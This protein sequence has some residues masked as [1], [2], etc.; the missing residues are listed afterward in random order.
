MKTGSI[1]KLGLL[2]ICAVVLLSVAAM[3]MGVNNAGER[4]VVQ[5]PNGTMFVKFE[6]GWYLSL[7]GK[8]NAYNDV[9]TFDFDKNVNSQD[10]TLDQQGIQ[11]RY[12]D[13]GTG[14]IFGIARFSLPNDEESMLKL[15]KQFRSYEGVAYKLIKPSTEESNNLT[16]ALMSSEEAYAEKRSTFTEWSKEQLVVGLYKTEI[17]QISEEDELSGKRVTKNVPTIRM[18]KDGLVE[19]YTSDLASYGV[20]VTGYQI[21]DWDFEEK[22]LEQ[23]AAKRMATMAIITAK[24]QAEEAKQEALTAEEKGKAA[25]MVAKY[26]KE[27]TKEQA[28]VEAT[29]A[30]EV[31]VI[32]AEQLV[33]VAEQALLEQTQKTL[34]ADQYKEEQILLG[35]GD[36]E[37]K[38]L[39]LEADGALEQKLAT[40][41]KVSQMFADA[42]S[43]Q[44]WVPDLQIGSSTSGGKSGNAAQ[45]LMDLFLI[46]SAKELQL[47]MTITPN[48][49]TPLTTTPNNR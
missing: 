11:V 14:T 12:Q 34:T 33:L 24:A 27:V 9:L 7:F 38:K 35:E 40:Y 16:A 6:P 44:K 19:H 45:N 15:H 32:E 22:T 41:E 46:K 20:E 17:K 2:G 48:S 39:V 49:S 29:Q 10:A 1:I 37:Y 21:T 25:V 42:I 8:V 23:I 18:G 36:A 26:E 13:G 31:A 28:L 4:T 43:K 30:Q 5:Y 47:D 3:T